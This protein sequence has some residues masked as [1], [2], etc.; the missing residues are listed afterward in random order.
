MSTLLQRIQ[1]YL[2][3]PSQAQ[4]KISELLIELRQRGIN[5]D[6]RLVNEDGQKY[7][8]A[9]SVDYPHGYI[10]ATGKNPNELERELKDAIFT[11]FEIPVRYCN[12]DLINFD[13]PV[14]TNGTAAARK[15]VYATT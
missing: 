8:Y 5:F 12:S 7:L 9:E 13:P 14:V 15:K 10:S 11:V 3:T 4:E 2:A 6:I 1:S